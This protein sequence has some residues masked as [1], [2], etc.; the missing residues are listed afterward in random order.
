MSWASSLF[1]PASSYS[2]RQKSLPSAA[3]SSNGHSGPAG[4]PPFPS[5]R[6][7]P[8]SPFSTSRT[9]AQ[10]SCPAS[11]SSSSAP[12]S[13]CLSRSSEALG[14]HSAAIR[15]GTSRRP[16]SSAFRTRATRPRSRSSASPPERRLRPALPMIPSSVSR[17]RP[18]AAS[19]SPLPAWH[20]SSMP[21][22]AISSRTISGLKGHFPLFRD[23]T[24]C[25]HKEAAQGAIPCAASAISCMFRIWLLK[26]RIDRVDAGST[27]AVL[28]KRA[29]ASDRGAARRADRILEHARL[30]LRL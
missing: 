7:L 19:Y 20:S 9:E 13:A 4:A 25:M 29:D 16:C 6:A 27:E 11:T 15:P 1:L 30:L 12:S 17:P 8:S 24:I 10:A 23:R 28:L 26:N 21:E 14:Q 18:S 22:G 2:H 3:T 5:S